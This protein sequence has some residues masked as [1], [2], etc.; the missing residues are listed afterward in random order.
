[1]N[2]TESRLEESQAMVQMLSVPPPDVPGADRHELLRLLDRRQHEIDQLSEE[3]KALSAKL[4][5]VASEKSEF[6]TRS[7]SQS[8]S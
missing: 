4:T 5:S 3:W 7:E 1:M 6:Q 2:D 8:M